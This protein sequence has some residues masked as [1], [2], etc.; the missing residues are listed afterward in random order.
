VKAVITDIQRFSLHD[1]PG[2]RTTVFLKGCNLRCAWCHNPETLSFEV[3]TLLYP[4]KCIHCG[5]CAE[6]CFSGARVTCGRE[7]TVEEVLKT[8]LED[9]DYYKTEGGLT[10][11][12]GEPSCQP[13][14]V[15]NLFLIAHE[16]GIHTAIETNMS[17]PWDNLE[18]VLKGA[19]LIMCDLKDTDPARHTTYTG[20]SPEPVMQNIRRASS[21]GKPM[22][23]RTPVIPGVNADPETVGSIAAFA[24]TLPGLRYYELLPYHPLG[25]SKA[26]ALQMERPHFEKPSRESMENL[27]KAA[28]QA[29][30]RVLTGGIAGK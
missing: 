13:D 1:G 4:E 27:R 25:D 21:L 2:I 16:A 19:D 24:S 20:V 7:M 18:K 23:L 9:K 3:Q 26:A 5:L 6:G 11:S 22:I 29:G 10:V 14:F 15:S 30:I 8:V 12:G 28:E 17:T